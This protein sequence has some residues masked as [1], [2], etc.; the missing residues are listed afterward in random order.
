VRAVTYTI[1]I[2]P[3]PISENNVGYDSL[4]IKEA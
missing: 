3:Y 4:P 1:K 2:G